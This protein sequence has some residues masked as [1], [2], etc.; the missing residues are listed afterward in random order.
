VT[1][2]TREAIYHRG[3]AALSRTLINP[4]DGYACPTCLGVFSFAAIEARVLTIEHAPPESIG[5]DP[6]CLT[7]STCNH[8]AGHQLDHHMTAF[9]RLVDFANRRDVE[10]RAIM[11][12][13]G[14]VQQRGRIGMRDGAVYFLGVPKADRPG[15]PNEVTAA[16][17]SL[18]A[19]GEGAIGA[20]FRTTFDVAIDERRLA[21]GWMRAAYLIAFAAL[22]Y[23]YI[24]QLALDR[25][26]RQI[27]DPN[28]DEFIAPIAIDLDAPDDRRV[29]FLTENSEGFGGLLVCFGKR[30]VWLPHLDD[31]DYHDRVAQLRH[32]NAGEDE[33]AG[34]FYRWPGVARFDWDFIG[35]TNGQDVTR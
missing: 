23:R 5:G 13:P 25:V 34:V 32:V 35:G 18:A 26:R 30:R 16:L 29:L 4:P 28:A 7:C 11:T 31:N 33:I 15:V 17:E 27:L 22:G 8:G 19:L 20:T 3:V 24:L 9:Q 2:G 10:M 6:V 14:G 12:V 1:D 21:I